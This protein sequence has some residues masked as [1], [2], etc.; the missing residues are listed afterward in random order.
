MHRASEE[1]G[2]FFGKAR[3]MNHIPLFVG[4]VCLH[5]DTFGRAMG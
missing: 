5:P 1:C 4:E 2:S 3:K